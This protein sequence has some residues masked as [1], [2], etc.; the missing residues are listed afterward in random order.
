M[1]QKLTILFDLDGTLVNTAEDLMH[2]HNHVM[3]KY[4]LDER[5]LSDIKK[6]AGKGAKVMLTKS[7][8]QIAELS[9][10][11]KKTD[12]VVEEMTAEFV[13]YYSKNIVKESTLKKGVLDFLTWCK[14]NS[15]SLGVCTNKQEHLA[16]DLL[17]K[18]KIYD[19]FDYTAGGNTFEF[20]KPDPRHLTN[21]IEIMGGDVKK[22]LMIGD[23]E[24]DSNAAKAANIPFI[25]I[26]DGYTEKKTNEIYH[27]YLSK[28]FFGVEK[29]IKKYL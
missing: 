8:H 16:I 20:N 10:K 27:D 22:S 24:T 29:I 25:L 19:F 1:S 4:G 26:E 5:E 28:D 7:M 13:D 2:A 6:L 14:E 11:I 12:D 21:T 15:I 9:G 23:S 3:K 17:K 18:I